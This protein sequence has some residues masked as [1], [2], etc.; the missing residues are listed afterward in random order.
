M[1]EVVPTLRVPDGFDVPAYCAELLG[2]WHNPLIRHRTAADRH[3]RQPEAAAAAARPGPRAAG[4]RDASRGWSAS[5]SR[6]GCASCPPGPAT[7]ARR[8]RWTTRSPTGCA[9][10]SPAAS[11][12]R[13]RRGRAARAARG[14]RRRPARRPPLPRAPDRLPDHPHP[15]RGRCGGPRRR[16]DGV[17][18]T[19]LVLDDDRLLPPDPTT[20][21]IARELYA[22]VR[23]LPL[24][25]MHGHVEAAVLATD[26]PF[27][28]PAQ[29]LVVP[30]HYVTRMLVS[31]GATLES[32][33]VPRLDGGPVETDM[34]A[35]WRRFCAGWHLF[36]GTPSRLWLEHELHDVF[37]VRV[38]AVRGDRRPGLRPDRRLPRPPG[39]PAAGAVRRVPA[40]DPG[41]HRLPDERPVPARRDR[42]L[43]LAGRGRADVPAGRAGAPGPARLE[44]RRRAAGRGLRRRRPTRTPASSPRSSSAARRSR[45]P[46]R[47]P[48]TTG[49]RP[50][51]RPRW[52]APTPSGSTP[53]GCA[54]PSTRP[55]RRRSRRTCSSRWGG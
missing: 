32:L 16:T 1:A 40:R 36:R 5:R 9:P 7:T 45:G 37:G 23:D 10:P 53:T 6:P 4:R 51:T 30:D 35:V 25:S 20:R 18:V 41:H 8:C 3:G 21:A 42:G 39:V 19:P 22:G 47:G 38:A 31:Q 46:A 15:R 50:P 14:L 52:S 27:P 11:E 33:G 24:V 28:D 55:A 54:A 17:P 29:L 13:G 48:P 49:T 43:G 12:P 26:D 34:R 2:R 44:G